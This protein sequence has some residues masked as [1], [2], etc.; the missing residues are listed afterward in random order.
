MPKLLRTT[1]YQ[2][3]GAVGAGAL[4][5][6]VALQALVPAYA[7]VL[8]IAL[9]STLT[10]AGVLAVYRRVGEVRNEQ[11]R[12]DRERTEDYRQLEALTALYAT[13]QPRA[14]LPP[15]RGWA[16]S[17]DFLR[18][19]VSRILQERPRVV[20]ETGC[21]ASTLAIA[22]C[23][24]KLGQGSLFSLEHD[25]KYAAATRRQLALHGLEDLVHVVHAPLRDVQIKNATWNWYDT[26]AAA[27]VSGP[28]DVLVVDGPPRTTQPQARYPAV[29][30]LETRLSPGVVILMDDGDRP[31]ERSTA[32]RWRQEFAGFVVEHVPTEKGAWALQRG[33]ASSK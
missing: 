11:R 8:I 3:L 14:P 30:V 33:A 16:A 12:Q 23:L 21:G 32:E 18:L 4:L 22:Y 26:E 19:V 13:L 5:V 2:L 28:I 1:D 31:D 20:V 24:R 29:P 17:P 10:L 9:V 27:A 7:T 15:L 25:E 6:A